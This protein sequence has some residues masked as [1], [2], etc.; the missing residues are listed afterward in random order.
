[1]THD[2][3]LPGN[4]RAD[5]TRAAKRRLFRAAGIDRYTATCD[6]RDLLWTAQDAFRA[7]VRDCPARTYEVA[8]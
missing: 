2:T 4:C 3:C 5:L 8:S 6:E 7:A 1:M